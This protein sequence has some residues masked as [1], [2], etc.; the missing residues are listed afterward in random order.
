MVR[1]REWWEARVPRERA[2]IA[3]GAAALVIGIAWAYIWEPLAADRSRLVDVMPRL[4]MQAVRVAAQ[5][6]EVDQLRAA[7]RA[8]GPS[9]SPQGAVDET[10]KAMGLAGV[11]TSVTSLGEGR[12]QVALRPVSFDSL[13]GA[14]AQLAEKHGMA[15][16]ALTV[17]AAGEPG[18]V[19]VDNLVLRTARGG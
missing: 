5:G 10:M 3:A 1:L 7:A 13:M 18:K 6:A 17:K 12:V 4:R 9:A 19:Q 11:V 15:V 8:R 2:I 16:D 14:V